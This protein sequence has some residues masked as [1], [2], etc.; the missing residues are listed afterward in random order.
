[1]NIYKLKKAWVSNKVEIIK[2][3]IAGAIFFSAISPFAFLVFIIDRE[4]SDKRKSIFMCL[5]TSALNIISLI[6]VD[7]IFNYYILLEI[8]ISFI[9]TTF[10][11]FFLVF[12]IQLFNKYRDLKLTSDEIRESKL[13]KILKKWF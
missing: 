8:S 4:F 7:F 12:F 13:N 5:S 6:L 11:Y 3:S 9:I 2:S 1:M 10:S